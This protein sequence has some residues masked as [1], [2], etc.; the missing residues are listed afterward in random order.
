MFI[1]ELPGVPRPQK[2]TRYARGKFFDPSYLDKAQIRWQIQPYAPDDQLHG[3]MAMD[4]TFFMPIPKDVSKSTRQKMVN[5]T[6]R[7]D[8]R[9]DFDNLAYIITNALK[10]L[11]YRD[12][13]QVVDCCIHKYYGEIPRTVLKVW[14]L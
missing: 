10:G 8:K 1:F 7:P 4:M 6:L 2:Q 12:D 9:P 5:G 11:I 14:Q 13:G 3:P